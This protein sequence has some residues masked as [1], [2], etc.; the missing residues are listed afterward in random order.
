M[1]TK[2]KNLQ[3]IA[4]RRQNNVDTYLKTIE[5]LIQHADRAVITFYV[6]TICYPRNYR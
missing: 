5:V 6:C 4:K 2:V 3:N 1:N